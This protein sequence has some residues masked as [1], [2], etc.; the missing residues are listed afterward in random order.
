LYR[1]YNPDFLLQE[2]VECFWCSTNL[3]PGSPPL[4]VLPDG[5]VD[6]IFNFTGSNSN[7]VSDIEKNSP[8]I[9]G[10]MT[11][12]LLSKSEPMITEMIGIRFRPVG[13]TAFMPVPVNELTD[14]NYDLFSVHTLFSK[15]FHEIIIRQSSTL[16]RIKYI[17][18]YF[19][20]KL[21]S[22]TLPD[23]RIVQATRS[24]IESHGQRRVSEVINSVSLSERQFERCF[25]AAVGISPKTFSNIIRFRQTRNYIM[26]HPKESITSIAM[27][28]GYF[29]HSH[30]FRDFHRFGDELPDECRFF[31]Q[32]CQILPLSLPI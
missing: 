5:C 16:E 7:H 21:K 14:K 19:I 1:E 30:L 25:I 13:I 26:L 17:E 27:S 28:C 31:T 6:I 4:K 9:V 18:H 22:I 10:T 23:K 2:F 3:L 32:N 29:D 20:E 24:I 11:G 12:P 15:E 8:F